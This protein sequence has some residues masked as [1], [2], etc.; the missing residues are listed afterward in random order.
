MGKGSNNVDRTDVS[1]YT[2]L[3]T[4]KYVYASLQGLIKHQKQA[5]VNKMIIASLQAL[6]M[7]AVVYHMETS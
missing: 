7:N 4:K 2:L 5:N 1:S 3:V 6:K